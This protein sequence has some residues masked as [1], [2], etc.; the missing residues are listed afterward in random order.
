MDKHRQRIEEIRTRLRSS[1][2]VAF[3]PAAP[4][5]GPCNGRWRECPRWIPP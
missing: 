2:K 3:A 4:S 5:D 1:A